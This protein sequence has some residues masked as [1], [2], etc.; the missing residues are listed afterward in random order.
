MAKEHS[1]TGYNARNPY[2]ASLRIRR[3]HIRFVFLALLFMATSAMA[4]DWSVYEKQLAGKIIAATGQNALSIRVENRSSLSQAEAAQI[5]SR[6]LSELTSLGARLTNVNQAAVSVQVTFSQQLRNYV[7]VAQIQRDAQPA[8][9]VLISIPRSEVPASAQNSGMFAIQKL[10]LW[11][12]PEK[13]LDAAV[14]SGNPQRAIILG[15][16]S[17]SILQLQNGVWRL[18]QSLPISHE[19]PWPRDLRGRLVL[20][21]DHLFD[22]YLPGIFCQSTATSP[23]ALNCAQSNMPW[24]LSPDDSTVSAFFANDQNFFTG[25]IT[26]GGSTRKSV[27][28]FFSA[29]LLSQPA[30]PVWILNGIKGHTYGSL[31]QVEQ[32]L[33]ILSGIDGHVYMTDSSW[34]FRIAPFNAGSDIASI[35]NNCGTGWQLL[36]NNGGPSHVSSTINKTQEP[37]EH[38][39]EDHSVG[40]QNSPKDSLRAFEIVDQEFIPVSPPLNFNGALN[41]LWTHSNASSVTAVI[42]NNTAGDYEAYQLTISCSQ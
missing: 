35:H 2:M 1:C 8:S 19:Q 5:K 7:W 4:G 14:V 16:D 36:A 10:L 17:V 30:D 40:D 6:L 26:S 42:H 24:P 9:V 37:N 34:D 20:R 12:Q 29:S 38:S 39:A 25:A 18:D 3:S 27:P 32:A 11:A 15:A 13:I 41:A 23:F 22:A 31:V 21:D 28:A 33:W